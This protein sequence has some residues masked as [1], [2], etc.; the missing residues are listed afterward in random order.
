MN[1][2]TAGT[3]YTIVHGL[4]TYL[5]GLLVELTLEV[6]TADAN[7][8]VIVGERIKIQYENYNGSTAQV[9]Y[10]VSIKSGSVNNILIAT[11]INAAIFA[12]FEGELISGGI[13]QGS[14][15]S[16]LGWDKVKL[17]IHISTRPSA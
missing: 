3:V 14:A 10:G 2:V 8:P 17:H 13:A 1:T 11:Q 7:M 15:Y 16:S 4:N 6:K 9:G 12:F 5:E